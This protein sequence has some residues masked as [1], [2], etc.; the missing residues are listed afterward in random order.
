MNYRYVYLKI[1]SY[2]KKEEK[3]GLRVKGNGCIY[4][5]HH[6]LPKSLFPRWKNKDSNLVLLTPREHYFCHQ[7]LLKIYNCR[8]MFFAFYIMSNKYNLTS[9]KQYEEAKNYFRS[10]LKDRKMS[11]A[12]REKISRAAK[13]RRLS[14]EQKRKISESLKNR[15]ALVSEEIRLKISKAVK[16]AYKKHPMSKETKMKLS[17]L[18]KGK[19]HPQFGTHWYTDGET[20]IKAKE[21]PEGFRPGRCS[22]PSRK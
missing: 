13:G 15:H 8:E 3:L 9:S 20:N 1:I 16:A 22:S 11:K 14:E 17:L 12:T 4:E 7:L 10:Y 2:A 6:I 19:N 5:K 18:N 21:C